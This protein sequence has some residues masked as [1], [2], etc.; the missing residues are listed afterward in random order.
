[1][2]TVEIDFFVPTS[3]GQTMNTAASLT[4]SYCLNFT[5]IFGGL[6]PMRKLDVA[7]ILQPIYAAWRAATTTPFLLGS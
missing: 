5:A 4:S 7:P 1:M 2:N 6:D 3:H